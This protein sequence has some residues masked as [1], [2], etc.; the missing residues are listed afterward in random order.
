MAPRLPDDVLEAILRRLPRR[1]LAESRRVC[2]A[3]RAAV[4]ALGLQRPHLLPHAVRGVFVNFF[5][6]RWP[7][8]FAR[9]SP[10]RPWIHGNLDFHPGEFCVLPTTRRWERASCPPMELRDYVACLVFDP[11]ISPHYEVFLIPSV[12]EDTRE[13]PP[14][15]DLDWLSFLR[16]VTL[17]T[18]RRFMPVSGDLDPYRSMEWPFSPCTLHVLS[19]STRQWEARSFVREG[20]AVGTV[21]DVQLDLVRPPFQAHAGAMVYAGVEHLCALSW[22]SL[23]NGTYEVIRTPIDIEEGKHARPFLGKSEKGVYFATIADHDILR[24]WILSELCGNTDWILKIIDDED[25]SY[26]MIPE[27]SCEWDSD[28]DDVLDE[29]GTMMFLMRKVAIKID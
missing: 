27:E 23:T 18:K 24:V 3:W 2:T 19:S 15:F 21:E 9:P 5:D 6:Y 1:S 29:E 26:K 14:P 13:T 8:F 28:N 12:P 22:I 16:W 4:D 17:T 11:A 20:K 25:D 10:E 7:R